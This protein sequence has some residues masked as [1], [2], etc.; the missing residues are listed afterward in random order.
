MKKCQLL[1]LV[2]ALVLQWLELGS[3]ARSRTARRS[4]PDYSSDSSEE[5]ACAQIAAARTAC[6]DSRGR[7][8]TRDP[9]CSERAAAA[10]L[11]RYTNV[12][13]LH[14]ARKILAVWNYKT[15]I[16][17]ETRSQVSPYI[18]SG[19]RTTLTLLV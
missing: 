6:L 2:A 5:G 18:F 12:S 9:K 4:H 3:E 15:N 13:R 16:T 19:I 10:W 14:S 11:E 1:I 7:F 17:D 8:R